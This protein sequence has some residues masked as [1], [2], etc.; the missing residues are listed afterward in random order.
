MS[1]NHH[2]IFRD[3]ALKHYTQS[4]KRDILPNFSSIPTAI[5]LWT[6]LGL[7]VATSLLTWE[8]QVPLYTTGMGTIVQPARHIQTESSETDVLL[9]FPPD[10]ASKLRVGQPVQLNIGATGQQLPSTL[11][12]I[13][14][15]TATPTE[16]LQSYGLQVS[17]PA[18]NQPAVVA[19]INLGTAFANPAYDGSVV[20]AQVKVGSQS[21][22]SSLIS[23]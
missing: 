8:I 21:L 7:L 19:L 13:K 14:P 6:L 23:M 4:R 5:F 15:G 18:L 9:F 11:T 12:E 3:K 22:F 1:V 10:A 2:S 17:N 20:S 16:V